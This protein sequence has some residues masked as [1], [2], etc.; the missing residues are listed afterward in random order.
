MIAPK[1]EIKEIRATG[2][3]LTPNTCSV[4]LQIKVSK[5]PSNQIRVCFL[6]WKLGNYR[7]HAW[8][9]TSI[10]KN[11]RKDEFMHAFNKMEMCG[12]PH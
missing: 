7:P 2:T 5:K 10:L 12:L 9:N 6:F 1:S 11:F 8:C 4:P 3:N